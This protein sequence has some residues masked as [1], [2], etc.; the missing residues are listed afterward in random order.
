[1]SHRNQPTHGPG[2]YLPEVPL[3]LNVLVERMLIKEPAMRPTMPEIAFE[4]DAMW[5][6]YWPPPSVQLRTVQV[7]ELRVGVPPPPA[8]ERRRRW[9]IF[10]AMAGL[11]L[12]G[13]GLALAIAQPWKHAG[14]PV[15]DAKP[16]A[17]VDTGGPPTPTPAPTP[18]TLSAKEQAIE[19][20]KKA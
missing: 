18:R 11:G 20:A 2:E 17:A 4:L 13:G 6:K 3:E 14:E 12:A 8:V 1:D 5:K 10:A 16:V 19:D 15:V 9:P 7:P